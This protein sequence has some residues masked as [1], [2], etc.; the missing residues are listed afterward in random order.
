M[1]IRPVQILLVEDSPTDVELTREALQDAKIANELHH[2]EDGEQAMAFLRGEEPY[3]D[4]L[5]PDVVVLDLNLPRKD[6]REVLADIKGDAE[7]R[8]IP[9]IVLT[10]SGAGDDVEHAYSNYVNAYIRKPID[11]NE[12]TQTVRSFEQFWL[13]IVTLPSR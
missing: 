8:S 10:T 11:F 3:A 2:V 4:R 6:G 13:S 9:V 12:F 7:L 1:K 5:R